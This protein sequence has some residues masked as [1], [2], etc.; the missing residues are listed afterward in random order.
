MSGNHNSVGI[1]VS[2]LLPSGVGAGVRKLPQKIT[3]SI[4]NIGANK[5]IEALLTDL[6]SKDEILFDEDIFRDVDTDI[7]DIINIKDD[8]M[9]FYPFCE[10]DS[11]SVV[12][13]MSAEDL[14]HDSFAQMLIQSYR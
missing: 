2:K 3:K 7:N 9:Y 4:A 14:S 11:A 1:T 5:T 10:L 8:H 12:S 6:S 13:L